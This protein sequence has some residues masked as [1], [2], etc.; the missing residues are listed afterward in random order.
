M[1]VSN[2]NISCNF[3]RIFVGAH[4]RKRTQNANLSTARTDNIFISRIA[5]FRV[6][7]WKYREKML[8]FMT[9]CITFELTNSKKLWKSIKF[10]FFSHQV[11][12]KHKNSNLHW[13]FTVFFT[14]KFCRSKFGDIWFSTKIV[15]NF[16]F[17]ILFNVD[18]SIWK[19]SIW[20]NRRTKNGYTFEMC[21]QMFWPHLDVISWIRII[22]HL[23]EPRSMCMFMCIILDC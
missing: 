6:I 2:S 17:V 9:F 16:D 20:Q 10:M 3:H 19:R 18:C 11:D 13:M 7:Y 23:F 8:V 21:M 22:N 4:F 14:H 12:I 15:H 1:S 5:N